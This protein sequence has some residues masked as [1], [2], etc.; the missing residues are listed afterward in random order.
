MVRGDQR[1]GTAD[2]GDGTTGGA[3]RRAKEGGTADACSSSHVGDGRRPPVGA[4]VGAADR[5]RPRRAFR[6]P[7]SILSFSLSLCSSICTQFA[8]GKTPMRGT[9]GERSRLMRSHHN[10]RPPVAAPGVGSHRVVVGESSAAARANP[11]SP[12]SRR[13]AGVARAAATAATSAGTSA[14]AVATASGTKGTSASR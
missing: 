10:P 8:G 6:C 1:G 4:A 14:T 9:N 5:V 12:S 13:S 2:E 3:R 11:A 7:P